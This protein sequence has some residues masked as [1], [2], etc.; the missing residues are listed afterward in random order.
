MGYLARC[1]ETDDAA[2]RK[3]MVCG[4]VMASF[5]VEDF[6]L[7]RLLRLT[8]EEIAD[9]YHEILAMTRVEAF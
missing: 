4:T 1:G 8:Q 9:R 6:S 3:A 7:D 5:A 2:V